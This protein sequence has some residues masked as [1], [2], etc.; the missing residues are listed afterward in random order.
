MSNRIITLRAA[1]LASA[2]LASLGQAA[3]AQTD[4]ARS[5][6]EGRGLIVAAGCVLPMETPD[7][8]VA[9]VIRRLG[10]PLKPVPGATSR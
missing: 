9:A 10:G 2:L 4:D 6:A 3:V 8:N 7:A 5:Q 1:T